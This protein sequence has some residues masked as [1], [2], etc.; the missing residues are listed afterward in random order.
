MPPGSAVDLGGFAKGWVA[1]RAASRL[2]R[3]APALVEAGGDLAVSGPRADG[4]PWLITIADPFARAPSDPVGSVL[5]MLHVRGGGVATSGRDR[6]RWRSGRRWMHHIVDP[7][8]GR[9][10]ET[11]VLTVTVIAD[12]ASSAELAAKAVLILGSKKGLAWIERRPPLAALVVR[13]DGR[14]VASTMLRRHLA[15]RRSAF[16][17]R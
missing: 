12:S 9:P 15:K 11:D 10:A 8:T 17:R 13:E 3:V 4:S 6:R 2:G 5:E 14:V 7:R 1:D 16:R